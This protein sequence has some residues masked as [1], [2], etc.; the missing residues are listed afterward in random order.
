MLGV[1]TRPTVRIDALQLAL[2]EIEIVGAM[3]YAASDG[4]AD[5]Q[6]ALDTI[7]DHAAEARSLVTHRFALAAAR[8]AFAA[9]LD[10]RT[11]SIKVH[12]KPQG[13]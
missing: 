3:T 10:K 2:R 4:R 9:A 13:S 6:Q 1:F 11:Q 8:D 5:Y 12:I 7:A